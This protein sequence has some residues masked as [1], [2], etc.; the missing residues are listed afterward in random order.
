MGN[1]PHGVHSI[2]TVHTESFDVFL[3]RSIVNFLHGIFILK[4]FD[5]TVII[6]QY[7]I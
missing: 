7:Q 3:F 5:F 4:T 1:K 6:I 2:Q